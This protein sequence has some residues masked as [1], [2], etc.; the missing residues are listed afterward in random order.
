MHGGVARVIGAQEK[1]LYAGSE[2]TR[3]DG[4]HDV[5]IGADFEGARFFIHAAI[6]GEHQDG[7]VASEGVSAKSLDHFHAIHAGHLTV[8]H[9]DVGMDLPRFFVA[10][11]PVA[12]LYHFEAFQFEEIFHDQ[13][14]GGRI[15][16]HECALLSDWARIDGF[17]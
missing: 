7:N 1:R 11:R 2:A 6:G 10:F 13:A 8:C 17:S 12:C 3:L 5:I 16:D 4:L 14:D 15:F 9:D